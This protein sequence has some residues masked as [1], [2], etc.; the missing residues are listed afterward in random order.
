V[1]SEAS[2]H[3]TYDS[4]IFSKIQEKEGGMIVELHD[5]AT[6]PMRGVGSISFEFLQVMFLRWITFY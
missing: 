4:F 2:R 1:D 6:Y 3:V 5:D